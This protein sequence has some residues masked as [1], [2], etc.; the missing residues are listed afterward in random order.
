MSLLYCQS[1]PYP[2]QEHARYTRAA[3]ICPCP[4][5]KIA[6]PGSPRMCEYCDQLQRVL[7]PSPVTACPAC[8]RPLS[9]IAKPHTCSRC[10]LYALIHQN[11][12]AQRWDDIQH[13][14]TTTR[15]QQI[16]ASLNTP[17]PVPHTAPPRAKE[18]A[19][20]SAV[21]P[22]TDVTPPRPQF[23]VHL[24]ITSHSL[25]AITQVLAAVPTKNHCTTLHLSHPTLPLT[26]THV[27]HLHDII[28]TSHDQPLPQR[29]LFHHL[30]ITAIST[31]IP[32]D[33]TLKLSLD[34]TV[35]TLTPPRTDNVATQHHL[36]LYLNPHGRQP[37]LQHTCDGPD[38]KP[39]T[40]IITTSIPIPHPDSS[41]SRRRP[42][43]R[44]TAHIPDLV[45][46]LTF[47]AN[48]PQHQQSIM[49][50]ATHLLL[51]IPTITPQQS[52]NIIRETT[53]HR[54]TL[55]LILAT[56][57]LK[58]HHAVW[59]TVMSNPPASHN[60][61]LSLKPKR[62]AVPTTSPPPRPPKRQRRTRS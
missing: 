30:Q 31:L 46:T 27:Q 36:H 54:H 21:P 39:Y 35:H 60:A 59:H 52:W 16:H 28:Q 15:P 25:A 49:T 18:E 62:Q 4:I 33:R 47:P 13:M 7:T 48:T 23:R 42:M 22:I 12:F 37:Y 11:T 51:T 43:M 53:S 29:V 26:L 1:P 58:R 17:Q 41:T 61:T 44:T 3:T 45:T 40:L 50:L 8:A 24:A 32:G 2:S 55:Q 57:T 56:V 6:K 19:S 5:T 34:T 10:V 38:Q 20:V 14:I 9:A